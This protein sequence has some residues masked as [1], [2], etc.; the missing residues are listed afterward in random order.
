MPDLRSA[1]TEEIDAAVALA[2]RLT[3]ASA[4]FEIRRWIV[5]GHTDE[6]V[7][8]YGVEF[9]RLKMGQGKNCL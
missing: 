3:D 5:P 7:H 6:G 1:S 9:S 8:Q 4:E 2:V